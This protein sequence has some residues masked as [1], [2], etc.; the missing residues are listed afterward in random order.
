MLDQN[1]DR[2]W[3]VI[4]AVL[5]G[6]AILLL[7]NG[8]A[9]DL[10]AQVAGTYEDVTEKATDSAD[11]LA[12]GDETIIPITSTNS[13]NGL[14]GWK[15]STVQITPNQTVEEWGTNQATRVQVSGGSAVSKTHQH[16][17]SNVDQVDNREY[18][19]TVYV[20]NIG[21]HPVEVIN[22]KGDREVVQPGEA[23]HVVLTFQG[24]QPQ[25]AHLQ[26]NL[27]VQDADHIVDVML[28][29]FKFGYVD[30]SEETS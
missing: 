17:V 28:H 2:L 25:A 8:T 12:F 30:D 10:F 1:T 16:L 29:D 4:G 7:L 15:G 18:V 3:Y 5:I 21:E 23:S 22:N 24:E 11:E 13:F 6:A 19:Y 20:K 26:F 27:T 14:G 9:P